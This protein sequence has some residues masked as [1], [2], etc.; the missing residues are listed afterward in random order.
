MITGM[1]SA[2]AD[3]V[4]ILCITGQAPR[5]K[6]HKED[7]QAVDI[8]AIAAPV[9]KW[10]I[11]V[12]EGAQV[13]STFRK[14]FQIMRSGRPGPGLHR[15]ADRRAKRNHQLRSRNRW[16]VAGRASPEP[17]AKAIARAVDLLLEAA[18]AAADFRRRRHQCR[19]FG[20]PC[21]VRRTDRIRR[22]FR[23]LWVGAR[24]P[25]TIRTQ[26]G[27]DGLANAN[28]LRQCDVFKK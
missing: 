23:R 14:A 1:Y 17:N 9:A 26:C 25:T 24:S 27:H 13:P 22:S 7:F 28:P 11:T 3:S 5:A 20:R 6:L 19:G 8:A 15:S 12:M 4:P 18:T 2:I 10:S 16:A 21:A